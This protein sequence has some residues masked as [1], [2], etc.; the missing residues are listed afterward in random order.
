MQAVNSQMQSSCLKM[1]VACTG[2]T[3]QASVAS[4]SF[5]RKLSAKSLPSRKALIASLKLLEA[6][7]GLPHGQTPVL[8]VLSCHVLTQ[9]LE[10]HYLERSLLIT[11]TTTVTAESKPILGGVVVLCLPGPPYVD[12]NVTLTF[13]TTVQTP[14]PLFHW[15]CSFPYSLN[16][17]H[18]KFY[19]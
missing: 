6:L 17:K 3:N 11:F 14:I 7:Q 10:E 1:L 2:S 18:R 5:S 15:N 12:C 4:Q 16:Q 19:F 9:L 13:G 8:L